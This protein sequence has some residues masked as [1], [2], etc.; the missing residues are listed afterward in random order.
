MADSRHVFLYGPP[1]AGKLTV[2]R[3]LAAAYGLKLLD[4][5]VTID[6]AQRLFEFATKPFVE[7]VDRLRLDLAAAAAATSTGCWPPWRV[8]AAPSSRCSS[9]LRRR[10]SRSGSPSPHGRR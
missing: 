2:A 3:C 4:S 6:V 9:S 10:C 5:T 8:R 1:A 7:L